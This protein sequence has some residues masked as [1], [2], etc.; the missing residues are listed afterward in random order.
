MWN[1]EVLV[2][3][4]IKLNENKV[5]RY[6]ISQKE[7]QLEAIVLNRDIQLYQKGVDVYGVSMRSR[8]ARGPNVYS[9]NTIAIKRKEGQPTDRVTMRDTGHLY[10]SFKSRVLADE[11]VLDA[12]TIKAGKDLQKEWGQFIGLD[13]FSK[14]VLI[15]KAYPLVINHIKSQIL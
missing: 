3:K 10:S 9:D 15:V 14:E 6:V 11:L 2:N 1:L 5:F 13:E 7:I 8:Y 12:D 4:V